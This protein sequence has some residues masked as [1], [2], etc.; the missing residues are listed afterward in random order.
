MP[1]TSLESLRQVGLPVLVKRALDLSGRYRKTP[2]EEQ[3]PQSNART[4]KAL[5]PQI[6]PQFAVQAQELL[7]SQ[8]AAELLEMKQLNT[9]AGAAKESSDS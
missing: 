1:Q 5:P 9:I 8:G 7:S 4:V 2:I 6:Y 3:R